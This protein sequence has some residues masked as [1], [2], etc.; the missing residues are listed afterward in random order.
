M[1]YLQLALAIACLSQPALLIRYA[2]APNEVIGFWRLF[3]AALLLFPAAWSRRAS[4][5]GLSGQDRGL[6][7]ASAGLFFA[8][9]WSF[10]YSA[11]HTTIADCM[12]TFSTHPL[13]TG[14][15]AWAFFGERVRA[16]QAAAYALAAGG[17]AVL[18]AGA[19][20]LDA[21]GWRGDLAGL[22]SAAAFSGYIL[23]GRSVRRRLDNTVF[24]ALASSGAAVLFLV[25]GAARGDVW[26][27]YPPSFWGSVL[28]LAV[29]VS[30]GGHALFTH[31]LESI[32][33]NAL[34]CAKLL[35]PPLAAVWARLVFGEA[36][37]WRAAW[38]FGFIAA[39]VLV[40]LLPAR[41][42][43][44]LDAAELEE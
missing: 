1:I 11:Q 35:E 6:M 31:L 16:R 40:L 43:L 9:L 17:V 23:C 14:L 21:S 32:D 19:A 5:R 15:G 44:R 36:L 22:T 20:S 8:H 30:I 2:R 18:F 4:W 12:I 37:S 34:S 24:A 28:A 42:A 29:V 39:A 27:G 10:V 7:L 33:V 41:G 13:W 3:F 38:A 26:T 25:C